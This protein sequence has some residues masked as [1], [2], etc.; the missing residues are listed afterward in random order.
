MRLL[1]VRQPR[2]E[3]G[4]ALV[5]FAL[6]LPVFA[7]ALFAVFDVGRLVYT[8]SVL[9]QAAREGARLAAAEVSWIGAAEPGCVA[10]EGMIG[11]GNPGAHVCPVDVS[12]FRGHVGDAVNRMVAGL[13]PIT[14]VYLSCDSEGSEPT[15]DWTDRS[16]GSGNGCLDGSGSGGVVSVRVEQGYE[17]ITPIIGS[18]IGTLSLSGAASMTVN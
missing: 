3:R 5:E 4:Q 1:R 14:S 18:I 11:A 10:N 17:P 2:E 8:N 12:A 7:L 6:V 13:G 16:G 15:G 9:S